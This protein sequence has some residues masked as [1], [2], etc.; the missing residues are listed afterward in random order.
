MSQQIPEVLQISLAGLSL[1][2]LIWTAM[3]YSWS[4]LVENRTAQHLFFGSI[5]II[6]LFW[7]MEAGVLPGLSFHIIGFTAITL[8]MGWKLALVAAAWVQVSLVLIGHHDW[9]MLGYH[10]LI[11]SV[12]PI[13]FTYGFYWLVYRRL[14]HNPFIYIL[15][16]GFL[17]AGFTHAF[18]DILQGASLF[19]TGLYQLEDIWHNYWRYLPLM[20]FPEGVVNG[21]FISGMVAFH[22]RWLSTFD[23]ESYFD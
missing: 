21:M 17:N 23:E 13:V 15:V 2:I 12:L 3:K 6:T 9:Q 4:V 8:M 22:T 16:A 19:I 11:Q 5:L 18:S 10:Y 20:M 7:K 14:A 1:F